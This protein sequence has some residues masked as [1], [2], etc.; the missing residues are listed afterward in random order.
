MGKAKIGFEVDEDDLA[1]AKAYVARHGGSLNKLVS[2]LFA[3]LGRDDP[4]EPMAL[5]PAVKTLLAA[6]MGKISLMEAAQQL[7]LPDAGYVLQLLAEK[8]LPLPRLPQNFVA[9]QLEAARGALDECLIEAAST[10]SKRRGSRKSS[11]A[12]TI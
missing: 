5:D 6:S 8:N 2:A 10:A 4:A 1:R 12:T 9:Q 7:G 3:S 11:M